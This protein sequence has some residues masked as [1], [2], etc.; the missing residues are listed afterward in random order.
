MPEITV[1]ETA[2]RAY[3]VAIRRLL[4]RLKAGY[5]REQIIEWARDQLI[6]AYNVLDEKDEMELGEIISED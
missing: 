5:Q 6:H 2:L 3:K 4:R 1:Q